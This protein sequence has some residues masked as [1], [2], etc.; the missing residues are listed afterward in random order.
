MN[1]THSLSRFYR[2]YHCLVSAP[3]LMICYPFSLIRMVLSELFYSLKCPFFSQFLR[4]KI[5]LRFRYYDRY[6]P[7]YTWSLASSLLPFRTDPHIIQ[8]I[9]HPTALTGKSKR[10][11]RR[12]RELRPSTESRLRQHPL[13]TTRERDPQ[14]L[15]LLQGIK[16]SG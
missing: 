7:N 12:Q 6:C 15:H 13:K 4:K 11:L 8:P 5:P 10:Y 16:V 2:C 1:N 9:D 14:T 3:M